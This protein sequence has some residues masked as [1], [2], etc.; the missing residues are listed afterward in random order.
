MWFQWALATIQLDNQQLDHIY[1]QNVQD[2][3]EDAL[4][5]SLDAHQCIISSN[6]ITSVEKPIRL[7]VT[8][9]LCLIHVSH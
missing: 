5:E 3:F 4:V 2:D 7:Q 9:L 6:C 8:I 1:Y